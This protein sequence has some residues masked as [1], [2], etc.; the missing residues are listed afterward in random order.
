MPNGP[1]HRVNYCIRSH[2]IKKKLIFL[3]SSIP[4]LNNNWKLEL[5]EKGKKKTLCSKK[6]NV[7]FGSIM[8]FLNQSNTSQHVCSGFPES[9]NMI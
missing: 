2:V 4:I 9:Q 7:C 5:Q 1:N 3:S 6:S 8:L